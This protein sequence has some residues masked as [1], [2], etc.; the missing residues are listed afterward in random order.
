MRE[1]LENFSRDQA[2]LKKNQPNLTSKNEKWN[3]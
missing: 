1:K 3:N 2:D